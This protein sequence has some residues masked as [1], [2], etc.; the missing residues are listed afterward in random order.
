MRNVRQVGVAR[1]RGWD[2]FLSWGRYRS[3]LRL[4]DELTLT[5]MSG[6]VTSVRQTVTAAISRIALRAIGALWACSAVRP[7]RTFRRPGTT[8]LPTRIAFSRRSLAT[9]S[10]TAKTSVWPWSGS[11]VR[12]ELLNW[13]CAVRLRNRLGLLRLNGLLDLERFCEE[14]LSRLIRGRF[15]RRDIHR[16][17]GNH[18][19]C[20]AQSARST[21]S[22][23]GGRHIGERDRLRDGVR[24]ECGLDR[25]GSDLRHRFALKCRDSWRRGDGFGGCGNLCFRRDFD[26]RNNFLARP[27]RSCFRCGLHWFFSRDNRIL[28]IR[29]GGTSK[30]WWCLQQRMRVA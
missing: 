3:W 28:M 7:V 16:H 8:T 10:L 17:L 12:V 14:R 19:R 9:R 4:G 30:G 20:Y 25:S 27:G 2:H 6:P 18:R 13:R 1:R 26:R 24:L 23:W 22:D 21:R 15:D 29:Q 11:E 5:W